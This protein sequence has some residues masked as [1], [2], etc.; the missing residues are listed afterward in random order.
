MNNG[1][2]EFCE[3]FDEAKHEH[4]FNDDGECASC[5]KTKCELGEHDYESVYRCRWCDKEAPEGYV[6]QG[7]GSAN[8][9]AASTL[10]QGSVTIL[11]CMACLAVGLVGGL[12]IGRKKKP[13]KASEKE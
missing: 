11:G 8:D 9:P 6:P 13:A 1:F 7:Q 10:S 4:I 3:Y 2:C 12:I 5:G